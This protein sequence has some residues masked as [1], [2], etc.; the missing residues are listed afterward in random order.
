MVLVMMYA[1]QH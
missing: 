1:Q